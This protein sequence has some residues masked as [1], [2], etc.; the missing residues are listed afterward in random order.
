[1]TKKLTLLCFLTAIC[2][3]LDAQVVINEFSC[4][5]RKTVSPWID[6]YGD[7]NDWIEL[8]NSSASPVNI[9]GF[10]L[11]DDSL[12]NLK[13]QFPANT[14]I[15]AGGF[16]RIWASGRGTS[17]GTSYHTNFNLKQTKNN[18]E[19]IVLSYP[20][21]IRIDMVEIAQKTQKDH[22]YG[23]TTNGAS[24]W[25]IFTSPTI[26]ASNNSQIANT[27]YADRP[28]FSVT[29]GFY[30]SSVTVAIT[31]TEPNATIRYTTNGTLPTTTSTIYTGPIT[32]S[33]TTVLNAITY[34]STP[35]ILPSFIRYATYFIN[36]SHTLPV[37]S[38]SGTSLNTL[39]NGNDNLNPIGSF[40]YFNTSG[41]RT[42]N[43]Y[44][45]FNSHG[46][47]SWVLSHRS[48]DFVSRDEYGI[49]HSIEETLFNTSALNNYQRIILRAA[50]DDNF[51]ADNRQANQGS[52]HV[53]DAY[54]QNVVAKSNMSL[55]VRRGS[56]CVVYLNGAY[57][58]VYDLRDNPDNHDNIEYYYG[59]DKYHLYML[60]RWGQQWSEYGGLQAENDWNA[61]Y[62]YIMN[63][64][65]NM[66]NQATYNYVADRLDVASL[67][68][69]IAVNMFTVCTDWLNY[70]TCWWRG[71]DTL[72]GQ[73]KWKYQLWDNDATFDHYINYTGLPSTLATAPPCDPQTLQ[74]NSFSDPDGHINVLQKLRQNAGFNQF[75][76]ARM[77]DLWNTTFSCDNLIPQFDST[78]AL[79]APEMP[80]QC[81]RWNGNLTT[82]Q[83][84][85]AT[86]RQF[87]INR[88]AA[89]STGFMNCYNLTGPYNLTVT[90]DPV[91]AGNVKLNSLLLSALPWS[92]TYFGNI[93]TLL[94]AQPTG[95]APFINWSANSQV[96]NPN[97]TSI[98]SNITLNGSDTII[99]HFLLTSIDENPN[100]YIGLSASPSVTNTDA[101]IKFSVPHNGPLAINL[102]SST[103]KLIAPVLS[104]ANQ[105][106][107]SYSLNINFTDM[108][109]S[110]G[111]YFVKLDAGKNVKTVKLVYNK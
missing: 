49:N 30:P 40:E 105:Q 8:Y 62:A 15:A 21:G 70:N 90:A 106:Q 53:R 44:G 27:D 35:G 7:N 65:N 46:Q 13:W 51:P 85:H 18:N 97:A 5:N 98:N 45:D 3:S 111:M 81:T 68:D 104:S 108:N 80:Q 101:N 25:G 96:F 31:S 47:D 1:M 29:P 91:W 86:M 61:L 55:D 94:E 73:L 56:K 10:Y 74:G 28:D 102:Y 22:S 67:V 88:C 89:L 109:L 72:Q 12:N 38:I 63:G 60:K 92:G 99:A 24:T 4:S 11:S 64:A 32:V 103:G 20:T 2:L 107:G 36:V 16:L 9:S 54:I 39:A 41:V 57:W 95:S 23:R 66:A 26:N 83:N 71:T 17:S 6:N 77:I 69:Y 82:W 14:N 37:V 93:Q 48:L 33:A 75:Y 34:S 52:A 50:G 84:N 78:I 42:A 79:I 59:V 43:T 19:W 76:I 87:I 100:S 110:S 58:G